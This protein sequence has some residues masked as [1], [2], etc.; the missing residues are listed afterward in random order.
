MNEEQIVI[1]TEENEVVIDVENTEL[2][3]EQQEV[4]EHIEVVEPETISIEIKEGFGWVGGDTSK[5]YS[6]SGR[7]EP[8]QHIISAITGLE[9]ILKKYLL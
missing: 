3:I 6:L 9:D 1:Q 7:D 5:H 8:D 2:N 4:V